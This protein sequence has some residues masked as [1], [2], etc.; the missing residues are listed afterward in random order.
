MDLSQK[1]IVA[2]NANVTAV[3][4]LLD[5]NGEPLYTPR[6]PAGQPPEPITITLM[7][8]D[9]DAYVK[10]D[11]AQKNRRFAAGTRMKVTSEA[12]KAE[13]IRR[14]AT[15]TVAWSH[16]GLPGEDETPH[17]FENAVRLYSL[18]P[19]VKDQ[20]QAFVDERANFSKASQTT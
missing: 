4:H 1:T 6:G 2:E 13:E 19:D 17:S 5:V 12:L 3:L 20:V 7:G 14:L 10:L 9:S 8:A 16:V 18:F 15:V 11:N